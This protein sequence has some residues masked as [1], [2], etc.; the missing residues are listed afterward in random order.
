MKFIPPVG[1][2]PEDKILCGESI[3]TYMVNNVDLFE[4]NPEEVTD[5][6]KFVFPH[7]CS[8]LSDNAEVN[9]KEYAGPQRNE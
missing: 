7:A 2:W 3:C 5:V 6:G 1:F 8:W 9:I 4:V